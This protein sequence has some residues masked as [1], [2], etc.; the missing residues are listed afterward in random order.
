LEIGMFWDIFRKKE[1]VVPKAGEKWRMPN[2]PDPWPQ[3]D[4]PP[5]KILDVKD[6]WVR[7]RM[8]EL[9]PDERKPMK[10]FLQLY[11]LVS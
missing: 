2:K 4:N 7:Y 10:D 5:V 3:P 8:N 11:R 9:F 1:P 6:G